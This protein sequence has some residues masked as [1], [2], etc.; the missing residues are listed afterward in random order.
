M[1]AGFGIA[2]PSDGFAI[3]EYVGGCVT[4]RFLIFAFEQPTF[5]LWALPQRPKPRTELL[6]ICLIGACPLMPYPMIKPSR[7]NRFKL[8]IG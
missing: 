4:Y 2:Q 5:A 8:G 1:P 7:I 3:D 6:Q